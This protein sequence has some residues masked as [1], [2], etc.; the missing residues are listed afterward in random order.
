MLY[1]A[2]M[3]YYSAGKG[4]CN[5]K[6]TTDELEMMLRKMGDLRMLS[7]KMLGNTL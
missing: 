3:R 2:I 7:Q 5:Y 6:A 4:D 1:D